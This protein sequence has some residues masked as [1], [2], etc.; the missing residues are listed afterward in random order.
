MDNQKPRKWYFR[1]W[2]LVISF[3]SVGPFMLPL[4][5][6]N[7]GFSKK[8][9]VIISEMIIILSCLLTA[10]FLK[11]LDSLNEYYKLLQP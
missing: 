7:P 2:A 8:T 6:V 9:K 11:S 3:L 5:W 4:V 10:V 1:T